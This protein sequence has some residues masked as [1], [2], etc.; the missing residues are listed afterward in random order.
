MVVVKDLKDIKLKLLIVL[1]KMIKSIKGVNLASLIELYP[2]P[3]S[4]EATFSSEEWKQI[5]FDLDIDS[6]LWADYKRRYNVRGSGITKSAYLTRNLVHWLFANK[7]TPEINY[8]TL[9]RV[10]SER[11]SKKIA[12]LNAHGTNRNN[13]WV[14]GSQ[15]FILPV[16]KWISEKSS[17]NFGAKRYGALFICCCN[18]GEL[19]PTSTNMPLFYVRGIFGSEYRHKTS[20]LES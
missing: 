16:Q 4:T 6:S 8:S 7:N 13:V 3:M 14:C 17:R 1:S 10:L 19:I 9:K 20:L 5:I 2:Q 18:P 11:E 12:V 15:D